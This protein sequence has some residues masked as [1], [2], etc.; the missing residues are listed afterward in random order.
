L[1]RIA[2]G[3]FD[4]TDPERVARL[5]NRIQTNVDL[6]YIHY[7]NM[8]GKQ[9]FAEWK[10]IITE[11]CPSHKFE[12]VSKFRC[13]Y[14]GFGIVDATLSAMKYF[15]N[16]EYD[17]FIDLSGDAYPIRPLQDLKD[18]LSKRDCACFEYFKLPYSQWGAG[19]KNRLMYRHYFISNLS[20]KYPYA[21]GLRIPR[22]RK[23]LPLGLKPYGGRGSLCLQKRHV[24]YL[25]EF[26]K[27][28]KEVTRFF[29]RVWG[30]PETFYQTVLLNSPLN[31]TICNKPVLYFDFSEGTS[32]AKTFRK[33]DLQELSN[34]GCFFARKL[35]RNFDSEILDE[36]DKKIIKI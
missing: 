36:I 20:G 34:S 14:L 11:K 32:H 10:K 30:P 25:L 24:T 13:K 21:W 29:K 28:H 9:K 2:Y 7:D 5:V 12:I 23:L 15:E 31:F 8:I 6:V 22:L 17:Y 3:I 4:Y 18:E 26:L 19:N 33:S 16:F 1:T 27:K 35:N